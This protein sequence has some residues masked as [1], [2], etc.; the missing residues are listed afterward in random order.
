MVL[1]LYLA[2]VLQVLKKARLLSKAQLDHAVC[3]R[4]ILCALR[5]PF[6]VRLRS[7]FV[8]PHSLYLV[9][10]YYG[11]GSLFIHLRR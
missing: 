3:E 6:I 7:A 8:G 1:T 4:S 9:T 5:H 11:A 2:C 10:D